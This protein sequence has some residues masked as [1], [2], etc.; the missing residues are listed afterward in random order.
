MEHWINT[1]RQNESFGN[2]I[3]SD[4]SNPSAFLLS[5]SFNITRGINNSFSQSG[6]DENIEIS[7]ENVSYTCFMVFLLLSSLLGNCLVIFAICLSKK[8]R[9]RV[10]N[11][12]ILS[13]GKFAILYI[14]G[15]VSQNPSHI[16]I[17]IQ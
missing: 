4:E 3:H 8:L 9:R 7:V 2:I 14:H 17:I 5:G 12:F 16:F 6:C 15:G 11:F 10:T 13:L 1:S